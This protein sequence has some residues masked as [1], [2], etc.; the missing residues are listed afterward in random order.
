MARKLL[1]C[2]GAST[3]GGDARSTVER[4]K[5][6]DVQASANKIVLIAEVT[7]HQKEQ[8][9]RVSESKALEASARKELEELKS[10]NGGI[11]GSSSGV[12]GWFS[13]VRHRGDI[14]RAEHRVCEAE[15]RHKEEC[16]KYE[17]LKAAVKATVKGGGLVEAASVIEA[18]NAPS[19]GGMF[20]MCRTTPR[21]TTPDEAD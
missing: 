18:A 14:V 21:R 7:K 20:K 19:S 4:G 17:G 15:T 16:R 1:G 13:E 11:E 10:Q 5:L 12:A 6:L 3:A 9:K 8:Q 2:G